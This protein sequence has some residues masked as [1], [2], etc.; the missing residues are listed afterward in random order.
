MGKSAISRDVRAFFA[1]NPDLIP[2]GAE[3]SVQKSCKGRISQAAIKVFNAKSGM[4]YTEGNEPVEVISYRH[5]S[6]NRLR[7][8]EVPRSVA[9]RLAGEAA[10][11]RGYLSE[12][13]RKVAAEQFA[14]SL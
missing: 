5:P 1:E 9:R 3:T 11:K 6:T 7:K 14:K 12:H 2:E 8:A 13:A 10:G 4:T